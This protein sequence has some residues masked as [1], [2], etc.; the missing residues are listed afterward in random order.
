MRSWFY[1]FRICGFY[2]RPDSLPATESTF[3]VFTGPKTTINLKKR[4]L[5]QRN[6]PASLAWQPC[7]PSLSAASFTWQRPQRVCQSSLSVCQFYLTTT[8]KKTCQPSLSAASFTWQRPQRE[9]D[10]PVSLACQLPALPDNA[11]TRPVYLY[12]VFYDRRAALFMKE[13]NLTEKLELNFILFH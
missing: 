9:P 6:R 1:L 2:G 3:G 13:D 5:E 11:T 8:A 7:Q 10:S 12:L 4:R